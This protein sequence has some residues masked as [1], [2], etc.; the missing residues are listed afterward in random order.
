MPTNLVLREDLAITCIGCLLQQGER[1]HYCSMKDQADKGPLQATASKVSNKMLE[2]SHVTSPEGHH[3]AVVALLDIRDEG[4]MGPQLCCYLSFNCLRQETVS[5]FPA[6][7][8]CRPEE[9]STHSKRLLSAQSHFPLS[10][11]QRGGRT[12]LPYTQIYPKFPLRAN[13]SWLI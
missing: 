12:R 8:V 7:S 6:A 1:Q 11:L 5:L 9:V 10:Q 3:K 4:M 2:I 13:R